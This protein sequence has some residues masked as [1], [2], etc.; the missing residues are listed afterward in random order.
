MPETTPG[1]GDPAPD[2]DADAGAEQDADGVAIDR[3]GARAAADDQRRR[4]MI[5]IG[6]A[7]VVA[8]LAIGGLVFALTRSEDE[9]APTTTTTSTTTTESTTTVAPAPPPVAPLTGVAVDPADPAVMERLQRP[10]LVAKVD[11]APQAM[12]QVGLDRTDVVIELQVEGISRYMAVVHSQPV[13]EIGPIRSARTSDP[14]LL[15]MFVRPLVAWSGGNPTVTNIMNSTPWIQALNPDQAPG[16]YFRSRDKR[17]PHNLI[18]RVPELYARADQP[19][20]LPV[21][22][23]SYLAA[24]Q[25]PGGAP[26]AG[27]DIAVGRSP[28]SWVWDGGRWLRWANGTRQ[29]VA[30]AGQVGATNVVVLSTPYVASSA[31]SRSPEARTIGSGAAWVFTQGRMIEGT[32]ER[33]EPAQPWQLKLPGGAPMALTPGNTWVEL[34]SPESGPGLLAPERAQALLQG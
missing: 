14:D 2:A 28:S 13:D 17:A 12:P 21:P 34:P 22:L 33:A 1:A 5:A 10:A 7:A 6:A 18:A 27:F 8:L 16:A 24:G 15:A 31:D 20:A 32:W 9:P 30:G 4:K 25:D 19:P 3:S 23:F 26:V 29:T 11:N